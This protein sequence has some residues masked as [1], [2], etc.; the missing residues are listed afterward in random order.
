MRQLVELFANK[1]LFNWFLM[2]VIRPVVRKRLGLSQQMNHEY[3]A[4]HNFDNH[5]NSICS[6][7]MKLLMG[8]QKQKTLPQIIETYITLSLFWFI[9]IRM[10]DHKTVLVKLILLPGGANH[11]FFEI[12]TDEIKTVVFE[13]IE[14]GNSP[15]AKL[16]VFC[17]IFGLSSNRCF[18]RSLNPS[19]FVTKTDL[20]PGDEAL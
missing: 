5:P 7:F 9:K 18:V 6:A 20:Q 19:I 11:F 12:L 3:D 14:I 10:S 2:E 4:R 8:Q 1:E 15:K 13:W 17:G 16:W